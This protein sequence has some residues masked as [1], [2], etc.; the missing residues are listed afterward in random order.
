M[1]TDFWILHLKGEQLGRKV[2]LKRI[3]E[4]KLLEM[5]RNTGRLCV[6]SRHYRN[7]YWGSD[8][9]HAIQSQ[10]KRRTSSR[11][12]IRVSI[13]Q[14]KPWG[15]LCQ[16]NPLTF[17]ICWQEGIHRLWLSFWNS[18]N[19]KHLRSHSWS[20]QILAVAVKPLNNILTIW[21][22]VR[23]IWIAAHATRNKWQSAL[24]T[25]EKP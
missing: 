19:L 15:S 17:N 24:L 22:T 21:F 10:R 3:H 23:T 8:L 11:N 13:I 4:L 1:N 18:Q 25:L 2:K 14:L 16:T 5:R 6:D 7:L 12:I 20:L 9:P